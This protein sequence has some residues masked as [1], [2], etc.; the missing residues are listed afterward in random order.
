MLICNKS[1]TKNQI[2]RAKFRFIYTEAVVH[3][4]SAKEVFLKFR[5]FHRETPVLKS[6]FNKA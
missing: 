2:F 4:C 3:S 5:K 6:L 1:F